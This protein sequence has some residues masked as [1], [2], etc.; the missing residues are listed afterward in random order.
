MCYPLHGKHALRVMADGIVTTI[1]TM[2]VRNQS[3][4]ALNAPFPQTLT[5]KAILRPLSDLI[6]PVELE[7]ETIIPIRV[8][9]SYPK[10][11]QLPAGFVEERDILDLFIKD[12][13][14]GTVE[15][16]IMQKLHEMH[17]DTQD[18]IGQ[19]KALDVN[20]IYRYGK[21]AQKLVG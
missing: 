18:L 5:L 2:D 8:L 16:R 21:D 12:V 19:E 15:Q 20:K 6:K 1:Y 4:Q 14:A 7:N 10:L 9:A 13:K 3:I 17:F 11:R